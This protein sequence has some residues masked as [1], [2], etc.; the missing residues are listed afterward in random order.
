MQFDYSII[1][2]NLPVLLLGM[3]NT[4]VF[5]VVSAIIGLFVGLGIA[6][7]RNSRSH[8]IAAV[9][10]RWLAVAFVE[11]LRNT[12]FLVQ[13]FLVYFGLAEWGLR[14]NAWICGILILSLYAAANFSESIRSGLLSVPAGQ[15]EAAKALGFR[16]MFI[17]FR[18]IIPQS[19]GYLVPTLT[20]QFIGLIKDSAALSVITVPEV[21]MA[22]QK[23]VGTTFS[24]VETYAAVAFL[25]WV[26]TSCLA[27]VLMRMEHRWSSWRRARETGAPLNTPTCAT[28]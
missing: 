26:V 9:A 1:V 2:R 11:L 15:T 7:I 16:P 25:Y 4:I 21:A 17:V 14:L 24:P 13:A 6:L 19:V 8:G 22:A 3:G 27:S 28:T 23:I 18:I 12:P 10:A 20:N 5:C